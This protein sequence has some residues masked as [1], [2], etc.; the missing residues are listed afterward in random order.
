MDDE[1]LVLEKD[2]EAVLARSYPKQDTRNDDKYLACVSLTDL[3]RWLAVPPL[4]TTLRVNTTAVTAI[5]AKELLKAE[6]KK[7]EKEV[8]VDLPCG[9]AVLRGADV[10]KQGILGAPSTMLAGERVKVMADVDGSC[11][12][13]FTKEYQGRKMYVG[14]GVSTVSREE[15]FCTKSETLRGVGIQMTEALYQAPSLSNTLSSV[16]FPQNLPSVICGHVLDPKPGQT[17]LD[18]CAAPGGKTTHIAMLMK[19]QGRV[20]ALDKTTDKVSRI[21]TSVDNFKLTCV[22]TFAFDARKAAAQDAEMSGGPPYPPA[23]FDCVL[24]DGPCSALGQRPSVR[25]K[26]NAST[27]ASFP[28]L[29]RMLLTTAV[30]LVRP[31][32]V[33]VYSTC[34]IPVE[35]N[36]DQVAWVLDTYPDMVLE[37]QTPHLGGCG[38]PH[39]QLSE[40]DRSLVQRFGPSL[41]TDEE[42]EACDTDTIGFFIA[43]FRKQITAS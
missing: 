11:L 35:E 7:A 37:R 36:E 19:N 8:I 30:S 32:G 12:R 21:Q 3:L 31:G 23:M 15:L 24:L 33:L 2:V 14:T 20:I 10:F 5:E 1:I 29:Q 17:V 27:L 13:G 9:M 40:T 39:T 18:V 26:M 34:T 42:N 6:L 22:E 38:L 16:V 43:K 25:N 4:Y 41:Q 28:K